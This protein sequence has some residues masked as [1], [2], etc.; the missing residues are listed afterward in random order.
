MGVVTGVHGVDGELK[1]RPL[2]DDPSQFETLKECYFGDEEKPR[3]IRSARFHA[4]S[5]LLKLAGIATREAADAFRGYQIR[6]RTSQLNPLAEE[7]YFLYQIIGLDA[8]DEDGARVGRVVDLIETGS[9]DV[10]VIDPG[11]GAQQILLANLPE[12]IL[13]IEPAAGRLTVRLPAYYE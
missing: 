6:A 10:F 2:T 5:V 11:E 8:F 7:E 9:A 1:I 3:R 4:G 12:V 13:S